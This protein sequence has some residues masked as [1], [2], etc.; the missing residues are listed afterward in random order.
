GQAAGSA[1]VARRGLTF[2]Q[3]MLLALIGLLGLV[4]GIKAIAFGY[5]WLRPAAS[6]TYAGTVLLKLGFATVFAGV[7]LMGFGATIPALLRTQDNVARDAGQLLF[8]SSIANAIG[9]LLM[10]FVLMHH[11]EWGSMLLLLAAA[12]TAALVLAA[13]PVAE[14][15]RARASGVRRWRP[16]VE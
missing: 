1:L 11:F 5:A 2:A 6:A 14:W 8:V 4:A 12:A 3:C 16:P 7:P 15:R 10:S 9:F 13:N